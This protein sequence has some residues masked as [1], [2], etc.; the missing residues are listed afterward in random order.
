MTDDWMKH[1]GILGHLDM[2]TEELAERDK[3]IAE[4]E[5]AEAAAAKIIDFAEHRRRRLEAQAYNNNE[6]NDPNERA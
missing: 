1:C 2:T 3:R 4:L 6:E 5:A